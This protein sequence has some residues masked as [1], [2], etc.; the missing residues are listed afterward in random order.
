MASVD[1]R[2]IEGAIDRIR[3][4]GLEDLRCEWRRL[5]TVR[6]IAGLAAA[7]DDRNVQRGEEGVGSRDTL[8]LG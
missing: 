3:S 7:G 4:F 6:T 1:T 2:A 8:R 5:K